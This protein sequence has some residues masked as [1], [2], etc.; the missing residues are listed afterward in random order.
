M[1][2]EMERKV[3]D[4]LLFIQRYQLT[5]L[6]LLT[7]FTIVYYV[8]VGAEIHRWVSIPYVLWGFIFVFFYELYV[9]RPPGILGGPGAPFVNR[10][11][12]ALIRNLI[13]GNGRRKT[14]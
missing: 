14:R 2:S 9:E 5:S 7:G 4:S 12:M 1:S 6:A 8:Q 3:H 10:E 11:I 13:S